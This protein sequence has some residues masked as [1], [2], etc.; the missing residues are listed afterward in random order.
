VVERAQTAHHPDPY[1]PKPSKR[2][3]INSDGP[4]AYRRVSFAVLADRQFKSAP[5]GKV[6]PTRDRGDHVINPNYDPKTADLPGLELQGGTGAVFARLGARL[7]RRR[8]EGR[9]FADG[10]HRDG[11]DARR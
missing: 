11:D 2:D 4:L 5:E 10:V 1:D 9:D 7:M 3:T 6:P 8:H